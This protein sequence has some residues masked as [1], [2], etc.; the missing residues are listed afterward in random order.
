VGIASTL[1]ALS[2]VFVLLP[3]LWIFKERISFQALVGTAV[4]I[5][6]VAVIL[7]FF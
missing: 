2:P 7:L 3:S 1:M 4:A 5:G 6:G